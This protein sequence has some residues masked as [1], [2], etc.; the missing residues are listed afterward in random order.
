MSTQSPILL[1]AGI[2]NIFCGDDGFGVEVVRELARLPWPA[3][4]RLMEIGTRG[5]DLACALVSHRAA[6]LVDVVCRGGVPGTVQ[7][8]EPV[9]PPPET[10]TDLHGLHPGRVLAMAQALGEVCPWLRLVGCEPCSFGS[11]EEPVC[12]LS[13]PVRAAV[14]Q[15]MHL[16]VSLASTYLDERDAGL[17]I[18]PEGPNRA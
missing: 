5:F 10:L 3:E 1:I 17:H 4:V 12:G 11:D 2:G 15:A 9:L 14:P 16:V 18:S 6:I 13:D 8:I 7:V